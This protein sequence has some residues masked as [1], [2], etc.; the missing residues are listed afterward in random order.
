M[1]QV[2]GGQGFLVSH[3]E[4]VRGNLGGEWGAEPRHSEPQSGVLPLNYTHHAG[5]SLFYTIQQI[6]GEFAQRRVNKKTADTGK[7]TKTQKSLPK[8]RAP[9]EQI[10]SKR[11][12]SLSNG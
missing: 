2:C 3:R 1:R 6:A 9:R 12:Q 10:E 7:R 4:Q 11:R 5:R 8:S